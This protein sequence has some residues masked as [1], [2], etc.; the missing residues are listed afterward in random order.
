MRNKAETAYELQQYIMMHAGTEEDV[1]EAVEEF[2]L[3]CSVMTEAEAQEFLDLCE[4]KS[5]Y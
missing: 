4:G 5:K 1:S 2:E 3:I